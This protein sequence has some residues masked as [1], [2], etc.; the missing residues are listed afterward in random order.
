MEALLNI[1]E[2]KNW[3]AILRDSGVQYVIEDPHRVK[4]ISAKGVPNSIQLKQ[5]AQDSIEVTI[6]SKG[7]PVFTS[8]FSVISHAEDSLLIKVEW[9]V[10]EDIRWYPWE[11]FYG[12]FS[13][14]FR[15]AYMDDNLQF[16]KYHLE[17][18]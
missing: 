9:W 1:E 12:L 16:L 7:K 11:K 6:Q 8:G 5:V 13:E 3:N 15:E 14:S 4:W 18:K 17:R 2:W 10:R